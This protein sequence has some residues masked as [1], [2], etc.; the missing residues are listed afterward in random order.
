MSFGISVMASSSNTT[1]N[2]QKVS[3]SQN[4]KA[5]LDRSAFALEVANKVSLAAAVRGF[6]QKF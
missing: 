4:K 2:F 3:A 1:G 5:D 6:S